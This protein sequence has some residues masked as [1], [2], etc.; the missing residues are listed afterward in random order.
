[1]KQR[2]LFKRRSQI[3]ETIGTVIGIVS[4]LSVGLVMVL[5]WL[6]SLAIPVLIVI[7]LFKFIF[8]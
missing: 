4:F 2:N 8:G 3:P 7:A 1:M 6:A 5:A